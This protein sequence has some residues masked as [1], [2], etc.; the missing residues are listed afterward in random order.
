M[1]G[2]PLCLL[3]CH[4]IKFMWS[5]VSSKIVSQGLKSRNYGNQQKKEYILIP[6]LRTEQNVPELLTLA[7]RPHRTAGRPALAARQGQRWGPHRTG[8]GTTGTDWGATGLGSTSTHC[9]DLGKITKSFQSS[10]SLVTNVKAILFTVFGF[11]K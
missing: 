4:V 10:V 9:T 6:Y 5:K 2:K 7:V 11:W 1:V 3:I 8:R